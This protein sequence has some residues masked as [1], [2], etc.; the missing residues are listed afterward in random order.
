MPVKIFL[1]LIVVTL[2]LSSCGYQIVK[3]RGLYSGEIKSIYLSGFRNET[4]DPHISMY[5]TQAFSSELISLGIFDINRPAFDAKLEGLIRKITVTPRTL[6]KRGFALEKNL[7]MELE[8]SLTAKDGTLIKRWL[9][10]DTEI[11]R[12]DNPNYEDYYKRE[13]IQRAAAKIAR[14]FSSLILMEY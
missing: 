3:E 11:F 6:D 8:I 12:A 14:R 10:T 1:T 5:V 9:L 4:F 13:A 2:I 7:E